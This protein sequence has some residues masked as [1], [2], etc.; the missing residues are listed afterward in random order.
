M[1]KFGS[2]PQSL[3][4]R[5][6]GT[7]GEIIM[8]TEEPRRQRDSSRTLELALKFCKREGIFP[9]TG[10]N[11]AKLWRGRSE[12]NDKRNFSVPRADQVECSARAGENTVTFNSRQSVCE[13]QMNFSEYLICKLLFQMWFVHCLGQ[14]SMQPHKAL[15]PHFE[16]VESEAGGS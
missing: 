4:P 10:R 7:G 13:S 12:R 11:A 16:F 6:A 2:Y 3:R 5:P 15:H 14:F 8:N 9:D 1:E